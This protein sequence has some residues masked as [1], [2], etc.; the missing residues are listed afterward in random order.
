MSAWTPVHWPIWTVPLLYESGAGVI[1][2]TGMLTVG[3][4]NFSD[5]EII[6][7]PRNK[8]MLISWRLPTHSLWCQCECA[9]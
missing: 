6:Q 3:I 5:G 4:K 1:F 7:T 8:K 2:Q 9:A